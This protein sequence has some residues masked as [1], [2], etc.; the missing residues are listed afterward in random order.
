VLTVTSSLDGGAVSGVEVAVSGTS[1]DDSGNDGTMSCGVT[2]CSWEGLA[3]LEGNYE[4][5]ITAPGYQ[6]ASVAAVLAFAPTPADDCAGC[7]EITLA[8]SGIELTPM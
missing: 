8:P 4:L 5:T 7:P 1:T 3:V 2:G 6:P